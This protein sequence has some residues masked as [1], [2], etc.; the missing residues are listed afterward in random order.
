MPKIP[1]FRHSLFLEG[2]AGVGKTTA[3]VQYVVKLGESG[4]PPDS[5]LILTPHRSV[6][7]HYTNAFAAAGM[8]PLP[9]VTTFEDFV[10]AML[11]MF[12]TQMTD[13]ERQPVVLNTE[14]TRYY[15]SR[16]I[17]PYI[18][19]GVF[20]SIRLSRP[21]IVGQIFDHLQQ[22]TASGLE[23]EEAEERAVAA[24]E[25]IH[26]SRR[27]IYQVVSTIL[28]Q[29]RTFCLDNNLLDWQSQV[30]LFVHQ[31]LDTPFFE[32]S[33]ASTY[34]HL[35]VDNVEEMRAVE[36]DFIFWSIE[37]CEQTL[38]IYDRDGGYDIFAGV[39]P[40]NALQF[41]E[42]CQE[43]AVWDTY[44]NLSSGVT[45]LVNSIRPPRGSKDVDQSAPNKSKAWQWIE[46]SNH[47]EMITWCL[48]EIQKLVQ[49]NKVSPGEIAIVA[50]YITDTFRFTLQSGLE[51]VGIPSAVYRP[52]RPLNSEPSIK[53]ILTLLRLVIPFGATLPT[54]DDVIHM[55]HLL[56][57]GLDPIRAS[58]LGQAAYQ[59]QLLSSQRLNRSVQE[60]IPAEASQ[61]YEDLWAWVYE[62]SQLL[63]KISLAEFLE[64]LVG[65]LLS[66]PGYTFSGDLDAQ[67]SLNQF[68]ESA[69]NF[70]LMGNVH[71]LFDD[72]LSTTIEFLKAVQDG[73]ITGSS[74]ESNEEVEAVSISPVYHYLLRDRPAE[75][76]FWL[77][78][79]NPSWRKSLDQPITRPYALQGS[80]LEQP[81]K[82]DEDENQRENEQL[83]NTVL[84][85]LRRCQKKV[86]TLAIGS[87]ET[88]SLQTNPFTAMLA[89]QRSTSLP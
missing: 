81:T 1:A 59:G 37:K 66:Q 12:W 63:P 48:Q 21:R 78:V 69:R 75:Y 4:S 67:R 38:V 52:A 7:L 60:R 18:R 80:F 6:S 24:W 26:S 44:T 30:Q 53:A 79:H 47:P 61:R 46:V 20:Q 74:P 9:F 10:P 28:H 51:D 32:D 13:S 86:Y 87:E 57:V 89:S 15:L 8:N 16:F 39:D 88:P 85:L 72:S 17:D 35:I 50:P 49:K 14:L 76:Q 36:H 11:E 31:L 82:D 71:H 83:Q 55:L 40:F 5:T 27:K 3:A 29:Y 25:N 43:K 84:G 56:I 42:V 68:I 58:L 33:F 77:D 22:I 62:R 23:I 34:R 19:S 2:P 41:R 65:E 45:S 73:I 70:Q 64:Q 54:R